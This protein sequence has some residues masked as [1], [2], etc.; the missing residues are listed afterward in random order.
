MNNDQRMIAVC[1]LECHKC[2]ILQATDDSKIAQ[3]VVDCFKKEL[4]HEV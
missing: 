4:Y 1:G 2:D 3:E